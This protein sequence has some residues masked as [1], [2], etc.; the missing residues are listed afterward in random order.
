MPCSP[1]GAVGIPSAL[2]LVFSFVI[3]ILGIVV[4]TS[5]IPQSSCGTNGSIGVSAKSKSDVDG[6][7][8][9]I[10]WPLLLGGLMGLIGSGLGIF[11]GFASNKCGICSAAALLGVAGAFVVIGA[12]AAMFFAAVF[13]GLCDDYKCGAE[14][15][16]AGRGLWAAEYSQPGV[17]S[18]QTLCLELQCKETVDWACDIVSKKFGATIVGYLGAAVIFTAMGMTCAAGC[19]CP[20]KFDG[21]DPSAANGQG[22]VVPAVIGQP[23]QGQPC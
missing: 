1:K 14:N 22:N 13:A 16:C 6:A 21:L 7:L 12:L 5:T 20:A 2:A 8:P 17:C 15:A 18:E 11:G 3:V 19:C 23:V 4:M 10:T 9:V